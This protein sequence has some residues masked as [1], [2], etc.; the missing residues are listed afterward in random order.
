MFEIFKKCYQDLQTYTVL[1]LADKVAEG[2]LTTDEFFEITG[3][4]YIGEVPNQELT[5]KRHLSYV[6]QPTVEQQSLT[7]LAQENGNLK[8][9]LSTV[10]Q[11]L[12]ALAQGGDK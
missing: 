4:Q 6:S 10:E 5:K 1:Q 12:T 7:A 9:E 8:A 11:A 2:W 3:Q